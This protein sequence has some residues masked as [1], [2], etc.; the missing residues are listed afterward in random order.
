M[1]NPSGD[2]ALDMVDE[3]EATYDEL[4]GIDFPESKREPLRENHYRA[5]TENIKVDRLY[6]AKE[7][8]KEEYAKIM[9]ENFDKYFVDAHKKLLSDEEFALL[10]DGHTKDTVDH[11]Y[12]DFN[13]VL[14]VF[15]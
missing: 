1:D 14:G 13:L 5:M 3:Y 7:I 9:Q 11:G 10:F 8:T 6:E 4:F 2:D 12:W 15:E